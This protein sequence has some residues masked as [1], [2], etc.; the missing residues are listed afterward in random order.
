MWESY[1]RPVVTVGRGSNVGKLQ[2]AG[3]DGSVSV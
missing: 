1:N 2:P 3:C